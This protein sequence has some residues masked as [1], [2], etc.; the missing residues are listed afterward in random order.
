[1]SLFGK[2][3]MPLF[4]NSFTRDVAVRAALL[5]GILVNIC[6]WV[7]ITAT[8]RNFTDVIALHYTIYFGIDLIGPWYQLYVAPAI[9]L[10]VLLINGIGAFFVYK[11]EV[12]LAYF[13]TFSA[14]AMQV[15][16]CIATALIV[17]ITR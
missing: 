12:L 15:L 5:V 2:Y 4:A 13:L 16:L 6:I 9:G 11:R 17:Y 8:V 7:I 1:M 14:L 10:A 3:S